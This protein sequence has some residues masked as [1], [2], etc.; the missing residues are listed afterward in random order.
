MCATRYSQAAIWPGRGRVE[1]LDGADEDLGGQILGIGVVADP[2]VD[3]PIDAHD[4]LVVDPLERARIG[5]HLTDAVRR[6]LRPRPQRR[7]E[8]GDLLEE[9]GVHLVEGV[10]VRAVDVDLAD[11]LAALEIGTTISLLVLAKQAR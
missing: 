4:V 1:L 9:P 8:R 10:E 3:E 2:G 5:G 6:R 11:D 7:D